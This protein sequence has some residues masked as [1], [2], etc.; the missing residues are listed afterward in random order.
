MSVSIPILVQEW[1]GKNFDRFLRVFTGVVITMLAISLP[2]VAAISLFSSWVMGLYGPGFSDGW[3]ILV[4]LL[5]AAPLHGFSKISSGVLLAMNKAWLVFGL[6]SVWGIV[7]IVLA[8][9]LVG[10]YG[11]TG[12]AIAFLASYGV[13]SILSALCIVVIVRRVQGNSF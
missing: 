10:G 4:L 1:E 6:K 13:L 3:V 11:A 12:L 9:L 2:F 5:I 7:L 8:M